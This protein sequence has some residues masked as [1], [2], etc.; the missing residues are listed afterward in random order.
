MDELSLRSS[1][2]DREQAVSTLR[3]HL[4]AGRLTLEEFGERVGSAYEARTGQELARL[5]ADLPV[6]PTTAPTRKPTRFTAG[7]FAHIVRRGRLRLRKR[8]FV[9]SGMADI[10]LD[11]REA[12]IE[13]PVTTVRV[14]ALFGNVDVYVPEGVDADVGGLTIVGHRREWG[15]D[16][17]G[18]NA[19][20]VRVRV[21][22]LFGTV[23]IWR[24]PP[25]AQGDYKQIIKSL[26]RQTHELTPGES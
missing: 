26:R 19:P 6:V 25:K 16:V 4:L 20:A 5:E 15:R 7:L 2:A 14:F 13:S 17:F 18:A 9:F 8:T 3:E 24:V 22:G 21:F 12:R 1:D 23:D 11:L 10:D